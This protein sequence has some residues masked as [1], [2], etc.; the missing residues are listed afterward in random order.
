MQAGEEMDEVNENEIEERDVTAEQ[1]HGDDD[2]ERRIGQ[3]LVA[4][5]PFSFGSQGQELFA[6]RL[7]LH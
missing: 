3:L 5:M 4:R 1:K 7:L 2:D 6:A